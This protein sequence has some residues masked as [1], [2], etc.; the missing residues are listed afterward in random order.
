VIR[1]PDRLD[2]VCDRIAQCFPVLPERQ[3]VSES[4]AIVCAAKQR[5]HHE[6][7]EHD[8]GEHHIVN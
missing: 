1:L 7:D 3:E 8:A 6:R 4:R 5:V 2:G